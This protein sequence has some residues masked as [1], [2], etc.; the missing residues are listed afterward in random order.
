MP[1]DVLNMIVGVYHIFKLY[2]SYIIID[3]CRVIE[4]LE[5]ADSSEINTCSKELDNIIYIEYT[6]PR[7][8]WQEFYS[9][10]L[11]TDYNILI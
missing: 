9:Q 8:L 1:F 4:Y 2:F 10:N 6:S 7:I 11:F 5:W 3:W